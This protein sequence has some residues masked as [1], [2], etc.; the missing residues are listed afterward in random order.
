MMCAAYAERVWARGRAICEERVDSMAGRSQKKLD[1]A[2]LSG[3]CAEIALMLGSGMALYDGVEALHES[4][5]SGPEAGVYA[6]LSE[7]IARTG[8]LGAALNADDCWP[9]YLAHMAEVGERTGR[10][11]EVMEGL[12]GYYEREARVRE[13]IASAAAYP[14]VLGAM[15][16]VIVLVLIV[17][18]LP[19]FRQ[20]LGSMGVGMTESGLA[21][22]RLGTGAGWAVLALVV[23][24]LLAAVALAILLRTRLRERVLASLRRCFPPVRR[25]SARLSSSRAASVLAMTLSG[26]FRPDEAMELAAS[27]LTDPSA[28]RAVEAARARMDEGTAFADALSDAGLFDTVHGRMI[29]MGIAAGRE[30]QVMARVAR[31]CEEQVEDGIDGLVSIIE[32]TLVAMMCVVIGAVLLSVM[33]P[34]AGMLTSLM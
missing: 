33:L 2:A 26:G 24:L 34:M 11:E 29:R 27:V 9:K 19:V 30:D 14:M 17:K 15:L 8:S 31:A 3:F 32:P 1:A 7:N 13:A 20:V 23:L 10:L 12:S 5:G 25:L 4:A 16:S 22:M 6:R 28:R 21:L 18:V